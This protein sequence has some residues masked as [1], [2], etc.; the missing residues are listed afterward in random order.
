MTLS[1]ATLA[2][3]NKAFTDEENAEATDA[4]VQTEQGNVISAQNLLVQTQ[5]NLNAALT[6]SSDA[7]IVAKESAF[8]ALRAIAAELKVDL[9]S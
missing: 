4:N 7:H 3:L 5:N 2:L 6:V 9:P 1:D 8:T